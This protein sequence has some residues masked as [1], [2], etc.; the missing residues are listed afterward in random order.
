MLISISFR[1]FRIKVHNNIAQ[2][3]NVFADDA[4]VES[5]HGPIDASGI[6]KRI[7]AGILEGTE[8]QV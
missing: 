3:N 5:T 6:R 2:A 8:F 4:V 1:L 7:Y